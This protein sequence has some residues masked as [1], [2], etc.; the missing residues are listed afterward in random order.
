[1]LVYIS[2][3]YAI[4]STVQHDLNMWFEK[5]QLSVSWPDFI[6]VDFVDLIWSYYYGEKPVPY[7]ALSLIFMNV[8]FA[9][10]TFLEWRQ[11]KKFTE[12]AIPKEI[13]AIVDRETFD[14]SRHYGRDKAIFSLVKSLVSHSLTMVSSIII[15]T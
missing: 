6:E 4:L 10:E 7:F 11:G 9:F 2:G 8:T 14:K 12:S 3:A 13:E 1:M 5:I 15:L